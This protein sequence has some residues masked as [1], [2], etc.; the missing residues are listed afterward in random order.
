MADGIMGPA[1]DVLDR[2]AALRRG[3]VL[4]GALVWSTPLVQ[5][6]AGPALA[7]TEGSAPPFQ[8]DKALSYVALLYVNDAAPAKELR[9]KAETDN[10]AK[11][12]D[13]GEI[14][15]C[16]TA[17]KTWAGATKT[18]PSFATAIEKTGSDITR[19]T[20]WL[21]KGFTFI[22]GVWKGGTDCSRWKSIRKLSDGRTEIIFES[23]KHRA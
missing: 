13:A 23:A 16:T 20:L 9:A 1:G 5:A 3:A 10:T 12:V 21:P 18:K 11:W 8:G 17:L 2:R 6:M 19:M 22:N 4:G 14:P 7:S 15:F